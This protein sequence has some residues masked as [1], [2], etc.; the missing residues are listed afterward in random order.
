MGARLPTV[1]GAI[2]LTKRG[3]SSFSWGGVIPYARTD[4]EWRYVVRKNGFGVRF[5]IKL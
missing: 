1:S 2:T 4:S 3:Q 5:E